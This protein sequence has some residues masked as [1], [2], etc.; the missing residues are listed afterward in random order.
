MN[1][2]F[3]TKLKKDM[4]YKVQLATPN[5]TGWMCERTVLTDSERTAINRIKAVADVH[6]RCQ[7]V[8]MNYTKDAQPVYFN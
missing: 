6:G 7:I 8:R 2:I 4:G 1:K 5:C 3:I